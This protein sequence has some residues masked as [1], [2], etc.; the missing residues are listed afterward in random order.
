MMMAGEMQV[1]LQIKP[2][3]F[4]HRLSDLQGMMGYIAVRIL[5]AANLPLELVPE[6][7]LL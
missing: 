4:V 5:S 1:T 3:F 7:A 2:V 6:V